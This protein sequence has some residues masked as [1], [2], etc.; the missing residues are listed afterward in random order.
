MKRTEFLKKIIGLFGVGVIPAALLKQYK[1][2]YLLQCFV[3]GFRFYK[4]PSLL[5]EMK[6]GALLE[7]VR[8]PDNEHDD[9][10]IALHFNNEKIGYIPA[11]DNATLSR[12]MDAGVVELLA[13][14]THLQSEAATWENVHVAIYVLKEDTDLPPA[15]TYLTIL[16]TPGYYTLKHAGDKISRLSRRGKKIMDGE[17]FYEALVEHSRTDE[18]YDLIHNDIESPEKMEEIVDESLL[19]INRKKL[20]VDLQSDNVIY[21]FDEGMV[22]LDNAFDESGYIVAQVDRVAELS[23]RIQKFVPVKDKNG[24]VFFEV[25]FKPGK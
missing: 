23:A 20:P 18:V 13:E 1:K 14:I 15:A 21:A 5:Q 2:L 11:E 4:G 24:Q 25:Q 17:D 7:L 10:A 3:R 19:L 22:E 6:E 16:E 12:L 8:E 9:C